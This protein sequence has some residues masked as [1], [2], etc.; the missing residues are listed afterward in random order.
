[1][2]NGEFSRDASRR[3]A[4]R[5]LQEAGE[6]PIHQIEQS[7]R[8]VLVRLPTPAQRALALNFMEAQA[9][10]RLKDGSPKP[11]VRNAALTEPDAARLRRARQAALTDFCHVL[12]NTNEFLY[13]D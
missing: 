6:D 9:R 1:M 3:L 8:I 13:L 11:G 10:R 5:V 12:L 7:Y 2:F 4:E